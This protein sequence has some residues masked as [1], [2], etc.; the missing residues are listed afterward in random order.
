MFLIFLIALITGILFIVFGKKSKTLKI[1]SILA[2]IIFSYIWSIRCL[3]IFLVKIKTARFR[4]VCRKWA[5]FVGVWGR[6]T[7]LFKRA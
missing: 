3:Y 7:S 2:G 6:I 5:V 1:I 4:C